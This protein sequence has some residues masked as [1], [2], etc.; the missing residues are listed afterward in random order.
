MTVGISN[1]TSDLESTPQGKRSCSACRASMAL[2]KLCDLGGDDLTFTENIPDTPENKSSYPSTTVADPE[3]SAEIASVPIRPSVP[4]RVGR[5]QPILRKE[6]NSSASSDTESILSVISNDGTAAA[7]QVSTPTPNSPLPFDLPVRRSLVGVYKW[8]AVEA[9]LLES[10]DEEQGEEEVYGARAEREE[11]R[12]RRHRPGV[13][14]DL[15]DD[16]DLASGGDEA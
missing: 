2:M 12:V 6:S 1:P 4:A 5:S 13:T 11:L 15:S 16:K 8:L 9:A 10:D 7:H 3:T 14:F